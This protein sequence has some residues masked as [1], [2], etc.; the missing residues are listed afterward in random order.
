MDDNNNNKNNSQGWIDN[1]LFYKTAKSSNTN[2]N[3]TQNY[4]TLS[5]TSFTTENV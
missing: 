1:L 4:T 2:K 5:K 3:Y